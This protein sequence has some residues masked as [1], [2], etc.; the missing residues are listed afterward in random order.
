[1]FTLIRST[2][3]GNEAGYGGGIYLEQAGTIANVTFQGNKATSGG[4]AIYAIAN[5]FTKHLTI[6]GNRL[7]AAVA[8]TRLAASCP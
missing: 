4:G 5:A 1:M 7:P 3:N 2:V 6:V 8:S